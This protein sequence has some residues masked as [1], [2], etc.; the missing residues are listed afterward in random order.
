MKSVFI[1]NEY[2]SE[3]QGLGPDKITQS[4]DE[5]DVEADYIIRFTPYS[6]PNVL[7]QTLTL[8]YPIS[9]KP[10]QKM[11]DSG[12]QVTTTRTTKEK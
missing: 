7:T 10:T 2:A 3:L 1:Q 5:Y 11:L 6:R 9:I 12:C 8:S 4:S